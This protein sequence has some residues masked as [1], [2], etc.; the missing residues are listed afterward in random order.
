MQGTKRLFVEIGKITFDRVVSLTPTW[1]QA[2]KHFFGR[3]G[4]RW[5]LAFVALTTTPA[6]CNG[7]G[8][9]LCLLHFMFHA[10]RCLLSSFRP[11]P[12]LLASHRARLAFPLSL[13]GFVHPTFVS[14][15]EP[16]SCSFLPRTSSASCYLLR[17]LSI[18]TKYRDL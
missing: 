7:G 6:L 11:R 14:K 15:A 3:H 13:S 12:A 8:S 18:L 17:Q 5:S 10:R 2:C 4:E 16:Y 9:C 1:S